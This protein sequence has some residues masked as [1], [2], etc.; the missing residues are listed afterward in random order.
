MK[1]KRDEIVGVI[2]GDVVIPM[3]AN[4]DYVEGNA[5]D[6]EYVSMVL[7]DVLQ[8]VERKMHI[9]IDGTVQEAR[10]V[11]KDGIQHAVRYT[12]VCNTLGSLLPEDVSIH[13]Y[14]EAWKEAYLCTVEYLAEYLGQTDGMIVKVGDEFFYYH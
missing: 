3:K 8:R 13:Q 5:V 11:T 4:N 10:T 7:G 9:A 14:R 1:M 12:A 2:T 6:L